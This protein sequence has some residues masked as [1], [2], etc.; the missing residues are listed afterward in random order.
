MTSQIFI[1][2]SGRSGTTLLVDIIGRHPQIYSLPLE[3][4]FITDPDG[5]INLVD[6][7]TY[8]YSPFLSREALYRFHRLMT[9]YLATPETRPY[10]NYNFPRIFGSQFYF[11]HCE[12][13]IN[14]LSQYSFQ[15][16]SVFEVNPQ[17]PE[18]HR[19]IFGPPYFE[20]RE[21][22]LQIA[23]SF[24]QE[25]FIKLASSHQK[26]IWCEKTPFNILHV[27]FLWEMFPQAQVL[28][29]IRDPRAVVNSL[30]QPVSW[31]A[32]NDVRHAALFLKHFLKRWFHV[33]AQL[34]KIQKLPIQI[35]YEDL[36]QSPQEILDN[37]AHTL[38]LDAPFQNI[39]QVK[40]ERADAWK[41]KL[42]PQ[43]IE[44]IQQVLEDEIQTL[45]YPM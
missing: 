10:L 24:V 4:R 32:P 34:E 30:M 39:P 25:L 26:S 11:Q 8:N 13:F 5:L 21:E 27:Q 38:Q 23:A 43:Q 7:L 37:L 36:L 20:N 44:I 28:H 3:M 35:K 31:W 29:I 15:G 45:Q 9:S 18:L 22:L 33:K 42:T 6:A 14:R 2:G 41:T 17:D 16:K 1:G 12:Q 19:N 40:T